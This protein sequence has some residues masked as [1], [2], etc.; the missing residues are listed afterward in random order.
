MDAIERVIARDEI[1]QLACRYALAMD[2]R[3]IGALVGLFVEDV[4]VGRDLFGREA[5]RESFEG[6][7]RDVGVTILFVG[8]RV[9]DFETEK[10]AQGH[11]Y[12]RAEVQDGDRW[13]NQA[14]LYR[15][16]YRRCDGNWYFVRRLHRLWYG[17]EASFNPLS[18]P[19]ANWPENQTGSGSLPEE[20]ETWREFWK[21]D[22]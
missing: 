2:S 17:V 4:Q 19:P 8:N 15:D 7:L 22:G 11:V 21:V 6:Q 1:H 10:D 14:I 16:R 5:L 9:I 12:C 13:I 18:L 20:W 3:D